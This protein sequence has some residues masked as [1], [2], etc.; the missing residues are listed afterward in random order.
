MGVREGNQLIRQRLRDPVEPLIDRRDLVL[1]GFYLS[2]GSGAQ[3]TNRRSASGAL[4]DRD[5]FALADR[6]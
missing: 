6:R 2:S 5:L 4:N 1:Q 3:D